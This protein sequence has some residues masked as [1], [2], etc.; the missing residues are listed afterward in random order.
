MRRHKVAVDDDLSV[1]RSYLR[2]E[3][4]EILDLAEEGPEGAEAV[5]L[6]GMGKNQLGVTVRDGDAFV[7]DVTGRQP[8]EVLYD[9]R[10]H[11][12]LKDGP[13]NRPR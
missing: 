2:D 5:L 1:Y 4:Y 10:K 6:S 3:G 8:E 7:L 9:L 13:A 12:A 11:F